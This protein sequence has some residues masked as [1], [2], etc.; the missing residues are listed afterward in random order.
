[1]I[2]TG[3]T[4]LGYETGLELARAGA[5]VIL[6]GRSPG[7]ANQ[8]LER[9]RTAVAGA[10]VRF[11]L[12]DLAS[13]ASVKALADKLLAEGRPIHILVNNAG[14]MM[15]P[16]RRETKDGFEL[17]FGT[18]YLGHYALTAR[19][20]PLLAKGKARI[21]SLS[22]IAAV[23]ASI[24]FDDL[25]FERGYRPDPSYGQ[26]KLAML[27][28]GLEL[29]RQSTAHGW[30]I[31]SIPAHPGVARTDLI[32][33]GPGATSIMG[34]LVRLL[35]FVRQSAARGALPQLMAATMP[36]AV[37]GG[38]Y[39]PD[40]MGGMRGNPRLVE[41][42]SQAKDQAVARRLWD[43]SAKLAGV[44]FALEPAVQANR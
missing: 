44:S 32:D 22:S 35:P 42:P 18:N 15:P 38:Y 4:G 23:P 8:S 26:S 30:G 31:T 25:Q 24:R 17:Q 27:M 21:V 7:P 14:V 1:V 34:V 5:E 43:I 10:K 3:P 37:G 39:G 36:D 9:I 13:L 11:E 41:P 6:A 12:L 33:K 28:F 40:G 2:V 20:L 29:Q 16:T 19:L